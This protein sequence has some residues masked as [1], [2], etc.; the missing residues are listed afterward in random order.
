M[1]ASNFSRLSKPIKPSK[2][3]WNLNKKN[4]NCFSLGDWNIFEIGI[5]T[6]Y[7]WADFWKTDDTIKGSFFIRLLK[8]LEHIS[9]LINDL[10][11]PVS[12][13]IF[14]FCSG[15]IIY[16][17]LLESMVLVEMVSG[18][19]FL[20]PFLEFRENF[21]GLK[22]YLAKIGFRNYFVWYYN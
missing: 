3:S 4:F 10:L 22:N 17:S 11:E 20:I 12:I 13:N 9:G 5:L 7:L 19:K 15:K 21:Q 8:Y 1:L 6:L 2:V 18:F 16:G 14:K